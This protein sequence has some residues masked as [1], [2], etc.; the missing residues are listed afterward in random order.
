MSGGGKSTLVSLMSR[1][2]DVTEGTIKVDGIDIRDVTQQSLRN[3]IGMVVQDNILF[4]ESI[5][6]NIRM[7]KPD[8]TDA[9]VIAAAKAANAHEFIESLSYKYKKIVGERR[10]KLSGGQQKRIAI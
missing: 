10:G 5:A 6:M 8:A 9:E 7:G 3:N 2:Y 1:F 4:S